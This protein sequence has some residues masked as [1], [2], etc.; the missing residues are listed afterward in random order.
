MF[1]LIAIIFIN[2]KQLGVR[3]WA[4]CRVI[5]WFLWAEQVRFLLQLPLD[6]MSPSLLGADLVLDLTVDLIKNIREPSD[7]TSFNHLASF[8]LTSALFSSVLRSLWVK[9]CWLNALT[10]ISVQSLTKTKS[11]IL[12]WY[13]SWYDYTSP[14]AL[15]HPSWCLFSGGHHQRWNFLH[16]TNLNRNTLSCLLPA[17]S[18]HWI[19]SSCSRRH[20]TRIQI[21]AFPTLLHR[22]GLSYPF[23]PWNGVKSE[24]IFISIV[25]ISHIIV[26][27]SEYDF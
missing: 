5:S 12:K 23:H 4:W 8:D 1:G 19:S 3:T 16:S 26:I 27:D 25:S 14:G 2:Q 6:L 9:T 7:T 21:L 11:V 22:P 15:R 18:W 20:W 10:A 13:F 17:A 24:I